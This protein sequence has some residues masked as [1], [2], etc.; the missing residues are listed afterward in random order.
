M[1]Y[2][3]QTWALVKDG[4][5]VNT[6]LCDDEAPTV[7]GDGGFDQIIDITN[8]HSKYDPG[9]NHTWTDGDGFRVPKPSPNPSFVWSDSDGA[10]IE[11][12]TKPADVEGKYWLWD[13]DSTSW[14]Q[15]DTPEE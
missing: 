5:V 10:W 13:E 7:F 8:Y 9:I 2:T 14:V 11:P 12:V 4:V 15:H 6:V 3:Q 1:T